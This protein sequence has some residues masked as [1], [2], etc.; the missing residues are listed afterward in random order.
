MWS[1]HQQAKS[2]NAGLH[3]G[4]GR[5]MVTWSHSAL[6]RWLEMSMT[7]SPRVLCD[8]PLDEVQVQ[9]GGLAAPPTGSTKRMSADPS[10]SPRS[11]MSTW[12]T[13]PACSSRISARYGSA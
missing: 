7:Q 10:T 2:P 9:L 8:S 5:G 4:S 6:K 1:F 11:Q 13:L 3:T 12:S